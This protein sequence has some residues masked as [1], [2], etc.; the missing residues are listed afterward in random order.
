MPGFAEV[1]TTTRE[2]DGLYIGSLDD[3][4]L[5][6]P[7]AFGG[8]TFGVLLD[9]MTRELDDVS[10]P[11]RSMT[12]EM[13]APLRPEPYAIEVRTIRDGGS[14][15]SMSAEATQ[16]SGPVAAALATFG[17]NRAN[18]VDFDRS[19]RPDVPPHEALDAVDSGIMPAFTQHFEYRF[20]LGHAPFA[21]ADEARLGGWL[22]P[23]VP[24]KLDAR[25]AAALLDAYPPALFACLSEFRPVS[26]IQM[27][28]FFAHDYS[29]DVDYPP[30]AQ[31]LVEKVA[32]VSA[33]GY[34]EEQQRVWGPDGQ[35]V[36][37]GRQ[38]MVIIR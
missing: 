23:D 36:A 30:D 37:R 38:T 13:A 5:Q 6:G 18:P 27:S 21:G 35:L 33:D 3:T 11:V 25:L 34:C 10:R 28:A 7:G 9:A 8:V 15:T 4:W 22:R 26:T 32:D 31:Y 12:V 19:S 2:E 16:D 29:G 14:V 17:E 1:S 20:C 24:T